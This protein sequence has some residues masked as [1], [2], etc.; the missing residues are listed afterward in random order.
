[1]NFE[2][3]KYVEVTPVY[4]NK[5]LV[6]FSS[7]VKPGDVIL[8]KKSSHINPIMFHKPVTVVSESLFH[9]LV[10]TGRYEMCVNKAELFCKDEIL[11][12]QK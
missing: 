7:N 8:F 6:S 10:S 1:M 5:T 2:N 11:Y 3:L 9:I 4:E 12:F